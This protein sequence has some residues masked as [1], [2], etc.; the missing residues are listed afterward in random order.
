MSQSSPRQNL[1]FNQQSYLRLKLALSLNLRRQ[2]FIAVCDDLPLR[3]RLASQLQADFS[4]PSP[5]HQGDRAF[6]EVGER[7]YPRLVTLDLNLSDPNPIVQ[8]A[9]WLA[10]SPPPMNGKRRSPVPAFQ[11]LG[12]EQLTRQSPTTQRMFITRLQGIERSLPV[13]DSS[14]L[15]W[16]P[17]PWFRLLPQSA[18]EFW[19]CRTGVFE[20]VGEPTPRPPRTM[21]PIVSTAPAA[22]RPPSP[23]PNP[24]PNSLS[25]SAASSPPAARAVTQPTPQKAPP[26]AQA[27]AKV[28]V[29]QKVEKVEKVET[30]SAKAPES[31]RPAEAGASPPV[32]PWAIAPSAPPAAPTG[33]VRPVSP[34]NPSAKSPAASSARPAAI[35]KPPASP[36]AAPPTASSAAA[37]PSSSLVSGSF[38]LD[39]AQTPTPSSV[40]VGR[41][42]ATSAAIGKPPTPP[43]DSS[44]SP[45]PPTPPQ[46]P[47]AN[48][49]PPTDP[50]AQITRLLEQIAH[51][52]RQ[53][54]SAAQL[55][56]AYRTLGDAY[57]DRIEQGDT[58]LPTLMAALQAYEQVMVRL[59]DKSPLWTDLLNDV[60]NLC[61]LLSRNSSAP[62]QVL[63]NLRQ[64]IQSYQL[65]LKKLDTHTQA[66]SY[67]MLHNN[68][69]AAYADLARY[70]QPVENLQKSAQSYRE[71]LRYRDASS[72]PARYASTQNNLG[73]TYWNLAQHHQPKESLKRAIAAY[74]EALK[75]PNSQPPLSYAMIQ[76]N[77]GTALWS[78]A[79]IEQP[80][81]YLPKAIAAYRQSLQQRTLDAAP[82]AFAATQNNLGT[83]LWHLALCLG[84]RPQEQL[85][86]LQAAIQAYEA[87]LQGVAKLEALSSP[88]M[89]SFDPATTHNNLGLAYFHIATQVPRLLGTAPEVAPLEKALHH[90]LQAATRWQHQPELRQAAMQSVLQTLKAFYELFG[91]AGQNQA[92]STVPAHLLPE[93]LPRL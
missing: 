76:N 28:D 70:E 1:T 35:A 3:D 44:A 58:S 59:P 93:L 54:A 51:L 40:S 62:D 37:K 90:H 78:L 67:P 48:L 50:D 55:Q 66:Q 24:S 17:Q 84:D 43:A 42:P 81:V 6:W 92:L 85:Q 87:A 33:T 20:F 14:L 8:V 82:A 22:Q 69:G 49:A 83:A 68:L 18:L 10:D 74:Q 34:A 61:W 65:A 9:Q 73:T 32:N 63:P 53:S 7:R 89:L 52:H 38:R 19:R 45:P 26:A 4:N 71:A 2:V 47:L 30:P 11:F 12:I 5:I 29:A 80:E 79:Q 41:S 88:A 23:S 46:P 15:F 13:L 27:P 56:D 64:A 57:R 36:V 72:D 86:K 39:A 60:G 16:M 75:H 77:L 25:N 31:K 21:T 91:T